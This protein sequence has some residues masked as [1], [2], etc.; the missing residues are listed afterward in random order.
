MEKKKSLVCHIVPSFGRK[1]VLWWSIYDNKKVK[2]SFTNV[3]KNP[4]MH[5]SNN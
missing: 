1:F 3:L 4:K 5:R 2:Y